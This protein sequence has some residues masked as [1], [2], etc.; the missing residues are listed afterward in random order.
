MNF[1]SWIWRP[2]ILA[3]KRNTQ[4]PFPLR[5]HPLHS[6][7]SSVS[8]CLIPSWKSAKND[9][10]SEALLQAPNS[11]NPWDWCQMTWLVSGYFSAIFY[12]VWPQE[13]RRRPG[14]SAHGLRSTFINPALLGQQPDLWQIPPPE[15]HAAQFKFNFL[16]DIFLLETKY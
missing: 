10:A 7:R 3:T 12:R 8:G 15:N 16:C 2:Y 5:N 13:Q 11:D 6:L 9:A 14:S 4:P 1:V